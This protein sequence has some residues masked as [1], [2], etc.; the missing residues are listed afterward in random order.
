MNLEPRLTE[1]L[2][3]DCHQM[4]ING[5]YQ[6]ASSDTTISLVNPSNEKKFAKIRVATVEDVD[7]AVKSSKKAFKSAQWSKMYPAYR[8]RL[9]LKL[10]DLIEENAEALAQLVTLENG[11]LVREAI[12]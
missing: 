2:E 5:Q 11:K 3:V 9:M 6:K 8:E 10:A 12:F 7:K 4:F 1:F